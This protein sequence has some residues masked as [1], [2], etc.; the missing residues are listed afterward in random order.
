MKRLSAL[1]VT[2]ELLYKNKYIAD[3]LNSYFVEFYQEGYKEM[4]SI[5]NIQ[6]VLVN[7]EMGIN[8]Y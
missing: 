7:I 4:D 3:A 1:R 2:R 6:N 8:K 5:L